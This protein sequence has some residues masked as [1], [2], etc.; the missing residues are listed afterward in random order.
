MLNCWGWP[1]IC[2]LPALAPQIVC[3]SM[4]GVEVAYSW[5]SI[6]EKVVV[7]TK[8]EFFSVY[9]DQR[10]CTYLANGCFRYTILENVIFFAGEGG[11]FLFIFFVLGYQGLNSG[12]LNHWATSPVLFCILFRD[13]VSLSC[14]APP[15]CWGWLW[16]CDPPASVSWAAGIIAVRHRAQ[17][18][19]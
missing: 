4:P 15:C 9:R 1:W 14:L 8:P 18:V 3:A 11:S 13:S 5:L 10:P 17:L 19:F 2:N 16:T 6:L 12:A 7:Y